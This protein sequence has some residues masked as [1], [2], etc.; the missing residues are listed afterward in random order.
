MYDIIIIIKVSY[1]VLQLQI[2]EIIRITFLQSFV[3]F[4]FNKVAF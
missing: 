1:I 2:L 4:Y 3:E